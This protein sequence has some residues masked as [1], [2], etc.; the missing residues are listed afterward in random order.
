M[1]AWLTVGVALGSALFGGFVSA[2]ATT[3]MRIRHE[4][5]EALRARMIEAAD[6]FITRSIDAL[7]ALHRLVHVVEPEDLDIDEG[8]YN[9]IKSEADSVFETPLADA[10]PRVDET[11]V[12]LA[13]VHLLFGNKTTSGGAASSLVANIAH[14]WAVIGDEPGIPDVSL[15]R[16]TLDDAYRAYDDFTTAARDAIRQ[17]D[18]ASTRA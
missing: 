18:L 10:Q 6:E 3:R 2:W 8:M 4:R 16:R 7:N 1:E 15:A 9:E 12:H 14:V 5:E 17:A 13:R 11:R